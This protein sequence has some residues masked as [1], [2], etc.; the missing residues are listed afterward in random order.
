M[1][2]PAVEYFVKELWNE[3]TIYNHYGTPFA[4]FDQD[5]NGQWLGLH[6]ILKSDEETR[7]A[8]I[9]NPNLIDKLVSWGCI[10]VPD[11]FLKKYPVNIGDRVLITKEPENENK[12]SSINWKNK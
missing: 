6:G 4:A 3:G 8:I 11:N 2:T 1:T 9:E 5:E 12:L 10:N 7:K